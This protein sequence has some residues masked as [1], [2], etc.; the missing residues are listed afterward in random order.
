MAFLIFG[1]LGVSFCSMG[2]LVGFCWLGAWLLCWGRELMLLIPS[3]GCYGR[4]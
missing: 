1:V 4:K 3:L 2:L